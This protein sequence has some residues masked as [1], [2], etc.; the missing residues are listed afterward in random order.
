MQGVVCQFDE[1]HKRG[2]ILLPAGLCYMSRRETPLKDI[3]IYV[4]TW[5]GCITIWY[6]RSKLKNACDVICQRVNNQLAGLNLRRV[7]VSVI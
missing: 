4:E 6:E 3:R 5:D 1:W 2:C 7:E